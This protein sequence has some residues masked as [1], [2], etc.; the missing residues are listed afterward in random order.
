MTQDQK[1]DIL[2]SKWV[3]L[4]SLCA[5]LRDSSLS[6]S[7][8]GPFSNPY[9]LPSQWP[10]PFLPPLGCAGFTGSNSDALKPSHVQPL[11]RL[12]TS[13]LTP[14][15]GSR[16]GARRYDVTRPKGRSGEGKEE[17]SGA[18]TW[19]LWQWRWLRWRP[20]LGRA[21]LEVV[22]FALPRGLQ[23]LSGDRAWEAGRRQH[24]SASGT[25][26]PAFRWGGLPLGEGERGGVGG[27]SRYRETDGGGIGRKLEAEWNKRSGSSGGVK[28]KGPET[29]DLGRILG[30]GS[31]WGDQSWRGGGQMG[32]GKINE[33]GLR[34][35]ILYWKIGAVDKSV[36]LERK[37]GGN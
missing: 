23:E 10:S 16:D 17:G 35:L 24:L 5:S 2:I 32:R 6:D 25:A 14:P 36:W 34:G 22:V 31:A 26:A 30:E 21:E 27:G 11:W 20:G 12:V 19:R 37:L 13:P 29:G 7:H 3:S 1:P 8:L 4:V 9:A 33:F 15:I 18:S 28:A